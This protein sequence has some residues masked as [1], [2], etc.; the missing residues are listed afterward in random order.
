[1]R[2]E[3]QARLLNWL[4]GTA[5][6]LQQPFFRELLAYLRLMM[7]ESETMVGAVHE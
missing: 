1:M 2:R 6:N 7:Q 5:A 3:N 4:Q